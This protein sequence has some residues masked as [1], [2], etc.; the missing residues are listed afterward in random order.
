MGIIVFGS[1]QRRFLVHACEHSWL[2]TPKVARAWRT[3]ESVAKRQA[4]HAW[5]F[6]GYCGSIAIFRTYTELVIAET[7]CLICCEQTIPPQG[8]THVFECSKC[9]FKLDW[10]GKHVTVTNT[11]CDGSMQAP[12]VGLEPTTL[13]LTVPRSTS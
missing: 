11:Q 2:F 10:N 12:I 1:S 13:G 4:S 8:G 9:V 7:E 6:E 5:V 3:D